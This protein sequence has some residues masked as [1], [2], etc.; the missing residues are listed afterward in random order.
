[1]GGVTYSTAKKNAWSKPEKSNRTLFTEA[2]FWT[3]LLI[4]KLQPA[5]LISEGDCTMYESR[6]VVSKCV[7]LGLYR[8]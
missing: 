1:M 8:M 3:V 5:N 2:Y 7:F 6:V 4:R